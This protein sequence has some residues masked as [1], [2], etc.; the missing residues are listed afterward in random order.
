[1]NVTSP[2]STAN[3]LNWPGTGR[4]PSSAAALSAYRCWMSWLVSVRTVPRSLISVPASGPVTTLCSTIRGSRARSCALAEPRIMDSHSSPS[5]TSGST[6]LIRADP[7]RRVVPTS[8]TR[9]PMSR[10][11]AIAPSLGSR[12]AISDHFITPVYAGRPTV[13]LCA[14]GAL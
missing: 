9:G 13:L 7:S 10:S 6:P 5:M 2:T 4:Q 1:M 14:S 3:R 11:V 12:S 8:S